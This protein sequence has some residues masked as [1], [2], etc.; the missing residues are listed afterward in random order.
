MQFPDLIC[1][2]AQQLNPESS[3]SCRQQ[4]SDDLC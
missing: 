1:I 3:H 4:V 2:I